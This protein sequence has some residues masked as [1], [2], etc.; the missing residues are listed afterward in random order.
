MSKNVSAYYKRKN[1]IESRYY[2]GPT[3]QEGIQVNNIF[4]GSHI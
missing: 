4:G 2:F 3:S 1:D